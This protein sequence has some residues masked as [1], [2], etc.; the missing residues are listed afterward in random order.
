MA[1]M[2]KLKPGQLVEYDL[3]GHKFLGLVM[4]TSPATRRGMPVMTKVEWC[5]LHPKIFPEGYVPEKDLRKVKK[6]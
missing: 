2:P 4:S 1:I 6:K 3:H 5:G